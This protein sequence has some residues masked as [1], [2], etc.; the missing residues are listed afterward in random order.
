MVTAKPIPI[1]ISAIEDRLQSHSRAFTSLLELIPAKY[2]YGDKDNT[3]QWNKRKQTKVQSVIAKKARLD[4][5]ALGVGLESVPKPVDKRKE[6][7]KNKSGKREREAKKSSATIVAP[8]IAPGEDGGDEGNDNKGIDKEA[9][10]IALGSFTFTT[11]L[12]ASSSLLTTS[13]SRKKHCIITT[14]ATGTEDATTRKADQR[15]R[16]ATKIQELKEKRGGHPPSATISTN[17]LSKGK[18]AEAK[19]RKK[20]QK[21]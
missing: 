10:E 19:K 6:R 20:D 15:A 1:S 8:V 3:R 21:R 17:K 11:E 13:T 9:Q 4:P 18:N 7:L 12:D 14:T 5:D 16:L 2:Y